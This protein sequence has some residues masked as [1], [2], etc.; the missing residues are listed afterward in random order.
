MQTRIF[1]FIKNN[2]WAKKMLRFVFRSD[3]CANKCTVLFL[4][5]RFCILFILNYFK[6]FKNTDLNIKNR[7]NVNHKSNLLIAVSITAILAIT[8][9]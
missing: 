3:Y 9:Q 8:L 5:N 7:Q 4:I 2:V 6:F 1:C